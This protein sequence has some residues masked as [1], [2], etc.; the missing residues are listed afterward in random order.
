[1]KSS[2]HTAQP[3][4]PGHQNGDSDI[5][6]ISMVNQHVPPTTYVHIMNIF[7]TKQKHLLNL[8]AL[9]KNTVQVSII[10]TID[11]IERQDSEPKK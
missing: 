1:M 5:I 7:P 11:T 3:S 4:T 10:P 2:S 8:P 9:K 6:N